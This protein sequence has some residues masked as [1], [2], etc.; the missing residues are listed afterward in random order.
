MGASGSLEVPSIL[1]RRS[2]GGGRHC[3]RHLGLRVAAQG[4]REIQGTLPVSRREDAVVHVDKDKGFFHCFGCGVGGD[5][6]KFVELQDKIN[7]SEAV[8]TLAGRFGIPIPEV[9]A[10]GE[11]RETA[12]EREA[13]VKIHEVALAYFREQLASPAGA[14]WRE[15]LLKDRGLTQ[16]TIDRAA[17]RLGAAGA[18]RAAPAAAE[19]R[20]QPAAARDE[21]PGVAARRWQRDRIGS[22]IG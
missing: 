18:R 13:L 11:Q 1:H 20:L 9:E 15:Y 2:P 22:A 4:R 7:F 12:A 3:H 19:G 21:R 8:R 16:E 5:V 10:S 14:R 17:D 6:F